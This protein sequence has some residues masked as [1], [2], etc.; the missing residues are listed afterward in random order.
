MELSQVK[1]NVSDPID[2][3]EAGRLLFDLSFFNEGYGRDTELTVLPIDMP[4]GKVRTR[5]ELLELGRLISKRGFALRMVPASAHPGEYVLVADP[6][7][8]LETYP[9]GRLGSWNDGKSSQANHLLRPSDETSPT[10]AATFGE[11]FYDKV[12]LKQSCLTPD[13]EAPGRGDP[14]RTWRADC[15]RRSHGRRQTERRAI[16]LRR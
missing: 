14:V 13:N 9:H 4:V 7:I 5:E 10:K 12:L 2:L 11:E 15:A 16:L 6:L 1:P 3:G 8:G